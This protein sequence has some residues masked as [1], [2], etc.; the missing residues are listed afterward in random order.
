ML[1]FA[2]V[3]DNTRT[4]EIQL[5]TEPHHI[6]SMESSNG[7]PHTDELDEQTIVPQMLNVQA[8]RLARP[9]EKSLEWFDN[10]KCLS[11]D[12]EWESTL[13]LEVLPHPYDERQGRRKYIAVS[14]CCEPM[15]KFEKDPSKTF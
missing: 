14:Y 7:M 4:T 15:W 3:E 13:R 11:M 1:L 5:L 12:L 6:V 10:L 2:V 8:Q 9:N